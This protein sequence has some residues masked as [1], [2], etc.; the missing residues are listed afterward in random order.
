MKVKAQVM[1]ADGFDRSVAGK[2]PKMKKWEEPLLQEQEEEFQPLE[3][4]HPEVI[5]EIRPPEKTVEKTVIFEP[6]RATTE[7]MQEDL[8]VPRLI[9]DLHTQLLVS[10]R[11]KKALEMDLTSY[12][13]TI[14]QFARD[15]KE[16]RSQLEAERKELQR[17]KEAH[18][19]SIYLKEENEEALQKIHEFQQDWRSLKENLTKTGRERDEALSRVRELESQMDQNELVKIRGKMKERE[20]S[21]FHEENRDLQSRLEEALAKNGEMERKY[22]ALKRSFSEVKESLT[23]L[24]DSYKKNYYNLSETPD[25]SR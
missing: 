10:S 19:E 14:H 1:T 20:A 6:I 16:L 23:L 5:Q 15:N 4:D 25:E 8:D 24:R 3:E 2:M 11:T 9:E 13:K 21:H 7:S 22:E 17:F 18:A 12:Q